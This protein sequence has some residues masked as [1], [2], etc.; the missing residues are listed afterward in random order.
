[1]NKDAAS[2]AADKS[3]AVRAVSTAIG[4]LR[5]QLLDVGKRNKLINAPIGKDRA[6]QLT[7]EDELS[8]EVFR[9][10]CLKQKSL[11]FEPFRGGDFMPEDADDESVFLPPEDEPGGTE[12][13]QQH[14]VDRQLQ[15][16]LGAERLQKRLLALYRDA[17]TL[18]EEQG[19][20][21]L[22]LALGFLR[23]YE[24]D[25]SQVER[26]APLILLPADLKRGSVRGRFRLEFR[27]QDMEPNLSLR[28]LLSSDFGLTLPDFPEGDDWLPT[29]Y[30]RSVQDAV[31]SRP[32][33][34]VRPNT[35]ELSFFSFGKFLM[36]RDLDLAGDEFADS[37]LP[38]RLLGGGFDSAPSIFAPD[39]N[40]DERFPDPKQLGHILDADTSQTQVIAAAGEGRNLVVQGPPGTGK[41][42]TIANIIAAAVRDGKRVLFVAEKR[43]ALDVVHDRLDKAGLGPLCLELHSHKANR[44]HIYAELKRTLELGRPREVNEAAY[45][46]VRQ[47]RDKL[48]QLSG[49]LHRVDK[50]CG[51][52]PYRIIGRLAE[53]DE[54]GCRRPGFGIPG[55]ESWD[56]DSFAERGAAVE[57]LASL[58]AAHG[59]EHDHVWR[60]ARSR[61]SQID[62]RA[63]VDLLRDGDAALGELQAWSLECEQRAGIPRPASAA[64]AEDAR[65]RL[66]ALAV[67]PRLVRQ[68]VQRDAV[69]EQPQ[70]FLELCEAI[71]GHQ[72]ARSSLLA[73]V[74][75]HALDMDWEAHRIEIVRRGRSLFRWLSGD[76]RAALGR[77]RAVCRAGLP[78]EFEARVALLDRL[79]GYRRSLAKIAREASLG[80][81]AL[82]RQWRQD[83]TDVGE[84]LPAARW[85]ALQAVAVGSGMSLGTQLAGID[86]AADFA[87]MAR[88]GSR[89]LSALM[90]CWNGVCA[91]A[92]IDVPTAFGAERV[93]LVGFETLRTRMQAW[94]AAARSIED[95]HRLRAA[96]RHAA[97]LGLEE[98]RERLADGR[99][100]PGDAR[101]A[102]EF[103]RAEAVW[104]RM[105]S[106]MPE[107]EKMDGSRRSRMVE[108]FKTLDRQLQTLSCREVAVRH[109]Q[110]LPEGS[111]G[112]VGVVRGETAKKTR[113][114]RIRQL[115]DKAGEAVARIKPVF[116]MSPLSVAQYLK[117][118]GLT[119]DLLLIDE[120]SQVRPADAMGAILRCR[121]MVVVGDQKQ[122]PPTSFFD[123]QV[124]E[125]V[126]HADA[127]DI[128]ELQAAQVGDMESILS[129]CESKAMAG[130][131]L[132]WHYRSRHPSLIEV[133][134]HEFYDY[135]LVCPPSP[136]KAGRDSGLSF[137]RV[138]GVYARGRKRNNPREAE[139]VVRQVLEHAR[140]HPDETLGVVALSVAQRDTI[141]DR[142]EFMRAEHPELE[143]FCNE[144]KDDAFFVKNLENV[145]GDERD[146]IFISICY[147][148]DADGY[149]SQS[150]GPVSSEGGERRLNVLFTRA[151]RR[152]RVFASIRH[153]DIRVD[154]ARHQG[155]RVLKRYLKYAETGEMDIPVLTGAA[156]DS[157]FEEAVA[158]ALQGHGYR[159]AAQVG[160]AGFR[161][162]LAV[163]DPDDEGRFLLAVECDGARYHSSSWARERDRLRQ[164]VLEQ[165]G[166]R[167]HRIWS[168]DWFYNRD[169]ELERLLAAIE[170]ARADRGR[171]ARPAA[172]ADRVEVERSEQ[173]ET[174][175]GTPYAEAEF[176]IPAAHQG[177]ELHEADQATLAECVARIVEI[178]GPVHM[179]EVCKRLSRLWG[180]RRAGRR[181]RDAV[182][183][184]A[185]ECVRKGRIALGGGDWGFADRADRA[186][187][188][189][190]RDRGEVR[191]QSLR[192]LEMLPPAEIR[193]AIMAAVERNIGIGPGECA[194]EVARMIGLKSIRTEMRESF[195]E[196]A[197]R[198][199][200][201]G[202]LVRAG[203]EL[204]LPQQTAAAAPVE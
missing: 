186:G 44:K 121:Q 42:Q 52:T 99:L 51:Q 122:M 32:R 141:R 198:L 165:K 34:R 119:F 101:D 203:D 182:K 110:S 82:G 116:L 111:A 107:L 54:R 71:A 157:P 47:V 140:E 139:E 12:A 180:Y 77:L 13:A 160:S 14:H 143:A 200:S 48:N 132:R 118:G 144:G 152:C 64:A 85:I 50:S 120:A 201:D 60:G 113:H 49:L 59:T 55:A 196:L 125:D 162:D 90:D 151:R 100:M 81:D 62:R 83:E 1:M 171:P 17:Q 72:A 138:D 58:T 65:G 93:E 169:A 2:A 175:Q 158:R 69:A 202:R 15:T 172:P 20:S 166:W 66:E 161:I 75:E 183:R 79:L 195:E 156:M 41:S 194:R 7:I 92:D 177:A 168:T 31:S 189:P 105:R 134:N 136:D 73:E 63:L 167:F 3:P 56:S 28:A 197:G 114:L 88:D 27:D 129:L 137:V 204:R 9:T 26:F 184:A 35:I 146:V 147:G 87:S 96:A 109:F 30:Y 117:P 25:S 145:Q 53:L 159:V 24:S 150:F 176:A 115:L 84:A 16:R 86:P 108:K 188:P 135:N 95:W 33:W 153:S 149:M 39:E 148:K 19:V 76:Y 192:T 142:L 154:A 78:R 133:S 126:E 124:S 89:R 36:W 170:R 112:Q 46:E 102:L 57:A 38:T 199:V 18:E 61:P 10:L 191:S 164:T 173:V 68:L 187:D 130:G 6:K 181:I 45:E 91:I 94:S 37:E 127:E 106:E 103:A 5:Q 80:S 178:E 128:A 8:D 23:W 11:T 155:T 74:I 67:M 29:E 97:E 123:R 179:D 131:M 22:F 4:I 43:A 21:V 70:R 193:A 185:G 40:L 190:V 174:A 98:L 163:W 104:N